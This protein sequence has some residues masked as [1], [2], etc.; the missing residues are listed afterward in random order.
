MGVLVGAKF[1]GEKCGW[2]NRV[3]PLGGG[4]KLRGGGGGGGGGGGEVERVH[5]GEEKEGE[6]GE[7]DIQRKRSGKHEE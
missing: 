6:R 5:E 4:R 3:F 2:G 7:I 1:E